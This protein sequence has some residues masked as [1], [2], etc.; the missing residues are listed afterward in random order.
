MTDMAGTLD[1]HSLTTAKAERR[2]RVRYFMLLLV[3]LA[4]VINFIDRVNISVVA[5]FMSKDLGIDKIHMG[6]IFSAFAWTY[7]IML[8]PRGYIADRFGSRLG[9][10]ASLFAWS[11]ATMFQ[12]VATGFVSLS[13]FRLVVGAMETPAFPA[14]ARAVTM[15][16]PQ[17]ERGFATS[18]YVMGQYIGTALFSGLL[19]WMATTFGWRVVFLVS[20][21]IGIVYG[22]IWYLLYRD[23]AHSKRANEAEISYIQDGGGVVA[24]TKRPSFSPRVLLKLLSYRQIQAICLGKFCSNSALIFFLTWFPT[25]LIEERH[26]QMLKAGIFTV[27]PYIGATIGILVAGATSDWMIRRGVSMSAARKTPLVVGTLMGT[28]IVLANF[29]TSDAVAIA[30]LTTAFFAQGV[31]STSWAAVS[32]VAPI[33]YVGL[34]SGLTSLAANIAGIVTP[35]VIGFIVQKT[36]SF[37]WALNFVGIL[38]MIGALS[39]SLLLGR[40]H[41]IVMDEPVDVPV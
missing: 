13:A 18:V 35:V 6:F 27:M 25:Y 39:Y 19:L 31:A 41:R 20:G 11:A 7:T 8:I 15:W 10:A 29:V 26:M 16:F 14:N 2:T 21:G 5:P 40:L 33:Q 23:P 17:R 38:A 1:V 28:T 22:V 24:S 36:G 37:T 4:T 3:L 12:G 30:I 9:Y 34:T 32:E